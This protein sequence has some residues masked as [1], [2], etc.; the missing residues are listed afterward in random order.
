MTADKELINDSEKTGDGKKKEKGESMTYAGAGV[1]IG[2]EVKI[3]SELTGQFKSIQIDGPG[4]PISLGG[5]FTGLIE[6]GDYALSLCTDGVGTKILVANELKKWDTIGIDCIA[7]NV[8]DTICVGAKPVA[9]VDY[10]AMENP[11]EKIVKEIGIGLS[12]GAEQAGVNI[13]GGETATLKGII[14]G[15]DLAGTSLGYVRKDGIIT[16]NN[17]REGDA[18]VGLESSGIHSNGLTLARKIVE[19]QGL[20]FH[21]SYPGLNESK[22]IGDVLLT[23]TKIYVR[24]ILDILPDFPISGLANITGGGLRNIIRLNEKV[25]FSI[26]DPM[27]VPD[28]FEKLSEWGNV[29]AFEMYQTFNM[30]L[31]FVIVLPEPEAGPLVARLQKSQKAKIIGTVESGKGLECPSLDLKY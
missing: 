8:N 11:S 16:G 3:I 30:G 29:S 4:K 22:R 20:T 27:P 14:N 9:F 13:I 31:G 26:T 7:M 17:I 23:P 18:L 10:L 2:E 24:D 21:S 5:H 1:D 15:I 25:C 12:V 19:N 28:I 6:F